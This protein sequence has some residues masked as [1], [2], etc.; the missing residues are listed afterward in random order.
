MGLTASFVMNGKNAVRDEFADCWIIQ[1]IGI[2]KIMKQVFSF[3]RVF[4]CTQMMLAYSA[5][6]KTLSEIVL[7]WFV[8]R[9]G[10][11]ANAMM[12]NVLNESIL[13]SELQLIIFNLLKI[14]KSEVRI[15]QIY[16]SDFC[17]KHA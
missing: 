8:S 11:A 4:S 14:T 16:F 9:N 1:A 13:K 3:D 6:A 7:F 2:F 10:Y 5:H 17:N 15:F 12:L